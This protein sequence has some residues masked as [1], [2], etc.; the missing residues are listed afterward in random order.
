MQ[1][2]LF[3]IIV[4]IITH[5]PYSCRTERKDERVTGNLVR[6]RVT[7]VWLN[8]AS[9]IFC[10]IYH[11]HFSSVKNTDVSIILLVVQFIITKQQQQQ[12]LCC[13]FPKWTSKIRQL[14]TTQEGWCFAFVLPEI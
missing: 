5:L 14:L 9:A 8:A 6:V 13:N 4:M 2:L 11:P 10:K 12:H 3:S 1:D 7:V